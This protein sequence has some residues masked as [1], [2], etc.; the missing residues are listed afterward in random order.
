MVGGFDEET[1]VGGR[2]IRGPEGG[3]LTAEWSGHFGE[4]W[5]DPVRQQF[6]NFMSSFGFDATHTP[7]GGG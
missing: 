1:V 7:W 6:A 5:N 2:L 4:N 3:F